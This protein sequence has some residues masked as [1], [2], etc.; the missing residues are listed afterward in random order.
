M[1]RLKIAKWL[2]K[3]TK[4]VVVEDLDGP[5]KSAV[6]AEL[7]ALDAYDASHDTDAEKAVEDLLLR[8]EALV[9]DP[10]E[11][12]RALHLLNMGREAALSDMLAIAEYS[13]ECRN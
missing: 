2:L 7:K 4:F 12:S 1:L 11:S 5:W 9:L 3:D 8:V 10:T 13:N 6:T